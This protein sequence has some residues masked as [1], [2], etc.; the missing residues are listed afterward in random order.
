[1]ALP[2]QPKGSRFHSQFRLTSGLGRLDEWSENASQAE[3]NAVNDAL[4]SIADR[5][6][7]T[8]F[9]VID[10]PIRTMGFTVL[11]KCGLAVQVHVHDLDSF[12]I[13]YVGSASEAP[14]LDYVVPESADLNRGTASA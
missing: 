2:A 5:T 14:G 1:M 8:E 12:G 13:V 3:R 6:V 4:F 9:D 7:F 11:A 10:D